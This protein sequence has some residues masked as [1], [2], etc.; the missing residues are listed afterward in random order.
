MPYNYTEEQKKSKLV[1]FMITT[2]TDVGKNKDSQDCLQIY[3]QSI[4]AFSRISLEAEKA[5]NDAIAIGNDAAFQISLK[6]GASKVKQFRRQVKNGRIARDKLVS[7]HLSHVI[8]FAKTFGANLGSVE[9]EDLVQA[10]NIGLVKASQRY[11]PTKASIKGATFIT[12]AYPWIKK[13]MIEEYKRAKCLLHIPDKR[14][15][16]ISTKSKLQSALYTNLDR[17]PTRDELIAEIAN[18]NGTGYLEAE[19][20]LRRM[21]IIDIEVVS[22]NK[23]VYR[24]SETTLAD[25][26]PDQNRIETTVDDVLDSIRLGES[27]GVALQELTDK[28]RKLLEIRFGI[29]TGTAWTLEAI[30][31]EWGFSPE[32]I[33]QME[34]KALRKLRH[35]S[36]SRKLKP[37]LEQST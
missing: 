26:I 8:A 25:T 4:S 22:L 20:A 1:K 37:F 34:A 33:R 28:E 10:G 6:P 19:D 15:R 17:K 12:Y 29:G 24:E 13:Y 21:D 5:L 35:P 18:V 7:S 3:L 14:M 30:A 2:G 9:M 23:K 11:D 36:R 16:L 27:L 32:R 31:K